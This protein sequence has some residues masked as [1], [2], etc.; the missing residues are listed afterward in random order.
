MQGPSIQLGEQFYRVVNP[1]VAIPAESVVIHKLRSEDVESGEHLAETLDDFCQ[2]AAGA[3]LVGHFVGV[4]LKILRK[5]MRS[6]GHKLEQPALC[7]AR[8]HHWILRHGLHSGDLALQLE[9]LDLP[10]LAKHYGLDPHDAHHALADAFL[11][12]RI[13]QKMLHAVEQRGI[14]TLGKLLKIGGV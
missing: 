4:D 10:S 11:T 3:A 14:R 8:I 7:T 13:W 6:T 1:R 2:F 5:E 9:K 12:A